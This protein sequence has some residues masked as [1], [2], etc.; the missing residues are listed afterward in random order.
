MNY[1]DPRAVDASMPCFRLGAF[2]TEGM[3]TKRIC[4][5]FSFVARPDRSIFAN[6]MELMSYATRMLR[7][8]DEISCFAAQVASDASALCAFYERTFVK[9]GSFP[10]YERDLTK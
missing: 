1:A 10:I 7:D 3:T 6:G 4:G 9:Q 2:G 8:D 5:L